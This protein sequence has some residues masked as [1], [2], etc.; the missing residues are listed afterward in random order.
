VGKRP[1]RC[2]DDCRPLTEL[3]ALECHSRSLRVKRVVFKAV[4][5]T[6]AGK[7]RAAAS[8]KVDAT[9]AAFEHLRRSLRENV[10]G[11]DQQEVRRT[12]PT[13]QGRQGKV[14]A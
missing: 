12:C 2:I 10:L 7:L 3:P 5:M 1:Q 13:A 11:Q 6:P 8:V 4:D 14:K 9:R